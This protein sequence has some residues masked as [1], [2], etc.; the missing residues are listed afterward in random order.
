[1]SL[2]F[3]V[4]HFISL[5]AWLN[6]VFSKRTWYTEYMYKRTRPD[7]CSRTEF[8]RCVYIFFSCGCFCCCC[9]FLLQKVSVCLMCE[10]MVFRRR[11]GESFTRLPQCQ[12]KWR[13]KNSTH[14]SSNKP[15]KKKKKKKKLFQ[16]H[17]IQL[18]ECRDEHQ[19]Y[20]ER[21]EQKQKRRSTIQMQH[22]KFENVL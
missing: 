21:G 19:T 18:C 14:S 16:E 2:S 3:F 13:W 7:A 5:A 1:M 22:N 9:S 10:R 6:S 4:F 17:K 8:L 20:T 12:S 11:I 15:C